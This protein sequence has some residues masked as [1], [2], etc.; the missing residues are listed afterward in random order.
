MGTP[1][2]ISLHRHAVD[3]PRNIRLGDEYLQLNFARSQTSF[4]CLFELPE[5]IPGIGRQSGLSKSTL[6]LPQGF[7][8]CPA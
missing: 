6:Y 4:A 2:D 1:H 3:E 8:L 5:R 7:L